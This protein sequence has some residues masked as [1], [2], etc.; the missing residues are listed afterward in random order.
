MSVLRIN[1]G[2]AGFTDAVTG[3]AW[4]ADQYFVG[5]ATRSAPGPV[6]P[7]DSLQPMYST[8]RLFFVSSTALTTAYALPVPAGTYTVRLYFANFFSG[9]TLKQRVP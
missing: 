2:G 8:N 4:G 1:A 6:A 7:V 9:S 3:L 5:G